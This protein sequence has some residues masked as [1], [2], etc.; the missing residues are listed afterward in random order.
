MPDGGEEEKDS[1]QIIERNDD[2]SNHSSHENMK[3]E[4][5]NKN[6]ELAFSQEEEMYAWMFLR[7][8]MIKED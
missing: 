7:K 4:D 2:F 5:E 1:S 6:G 8:F 3:K